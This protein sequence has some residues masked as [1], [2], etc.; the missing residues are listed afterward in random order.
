MI[1]P[2]C[3]E[4]ETL[5]YLIRLRPH[6]GGPI[7]CAVTV[8]GDEGVGTVKG[9]VLPAGWSMAATS[10]A[11]K[12]YMRDAGFTHVRWTR[13]RADGSVDAHIYPLRKE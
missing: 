13:H 1:R 6:P 9:L 7:E 8:T 5:V 4:P 11:I 10:E 2:V 12:R 3:D